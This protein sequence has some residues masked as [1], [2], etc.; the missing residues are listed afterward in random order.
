[1]HSLSLRP[2]DCTPAGGGAG[3]VPA[4]PSE[5]D[6]D[7][8]ITGD[9]SA[10]QRVMSDQRHDCSQGGVRPAASRLFAR[11]AKYIVHGRSEGNQ[12]VRSG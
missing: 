4:N 12:K 6:A 2:A 11:R 9:L 10:I 7:I 8:A 3:S 5:P 1:M